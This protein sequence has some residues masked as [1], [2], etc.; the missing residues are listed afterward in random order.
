M[1]ASFAIG[2]MAGPTVAGFLSE[3]LG[4]FRVASL[5]AAAALVI[6]AVLAIRTSRIFARSEIV[7]ARTCELSPAGGIPAIQPIRCSP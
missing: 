3:H 2:Q 7:I 4:D 5:I 1:T 6:S